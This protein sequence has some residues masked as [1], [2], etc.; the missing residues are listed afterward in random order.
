[1]HSCNSY[2]FSSCLTTSKLA[3]ISVADP[4]SGAFRTAGSGMEKSP[5]PFP[6]STINIPD[7]IS[8]I[9]L[10]IF[11]VKCLNFLLGIWYLFVPRSGAF[12][13][14]DPGWKNSAILQRVCLL[15]LPRQHW[16]TPSFSCAPYF[17]RRQYFSRRQVFTVCQRFGCAKF[18]PSAKDFGC[19]KFLPSAKDFEGANV[20][21]CANVFVYILWRIYFCIF[22]CILI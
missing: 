21:G 22:F 11:W 18:L 1:M 5:K 10:T 16:R 8:E 7:H 6:G 3:R 17:C 12:S 4:G 15:F 9:L 20:V 19:A 14:R 13:D 2:L